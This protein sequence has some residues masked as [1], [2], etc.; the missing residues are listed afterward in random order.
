MTSFRFPERFPENVFVL[1]VRLRLR[2]GLGSELGLE[3]AKIRLNI[4][5]R[6]N[7]HSGKCT[8][9]RLTIMLKKELIY[10]CYFLIFI[11]LLLFI[12]DWSS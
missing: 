2:L 3:L 9:S 1:R 8:R 7:V 11:V 4:R 6:L 10:F 12:F 5:F